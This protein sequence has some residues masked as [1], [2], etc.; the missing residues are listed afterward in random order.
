MNTMTDDAYPFDWAEFNLPAELLPRADLL[1]PL[2]RS[3]AAL[4]LGDMESR[5]DMR[6]FLANR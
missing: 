1:T 5:S 2:A 6:Q 4:S 3:I